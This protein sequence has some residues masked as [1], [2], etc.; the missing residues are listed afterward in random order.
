[1]TGER[2]DYL[3]LMHTGSAPPDVNAYLADV[4]RSL[5]LSMDAGTRIVTEWGCPHVGH[6]IVWSSG[7]RARLGLS[8]DQVVTSRIFEFRDEQGETGALLVAFGSC[9]AGAEP[10]SI[11]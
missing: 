4:L 9:A 2:V 10:T 7:W 8:D 5:R 11:P 6:E 1:M 3:V